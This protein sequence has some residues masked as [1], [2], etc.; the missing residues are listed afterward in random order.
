MN[1]HEKVERLLNQLSDIIDMQLKHLDAT[2][3]GESGK[4][5]VKNRTKEIID[6]ILERFT[7]KQKQSD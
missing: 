6:E 3:F 7:Q 1:E 2:K 5:W 4:Q